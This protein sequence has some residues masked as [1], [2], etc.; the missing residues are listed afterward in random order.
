MATTGHQPRQ[1]ASSL[2]THTI[3]AAHCTPA[4]LTAERI[5]NYRISRVTPTRQM[6]CLEYLS[7]LTS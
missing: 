1:H 3:S 6:T 2:L 4:Y 7:W 5:N